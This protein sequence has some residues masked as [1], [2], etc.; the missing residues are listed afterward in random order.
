MLNAFS[1]DVEEHFQVHNFDARIG[2]EKWSNHESRLERSIDR[3]LRLLER[4]Q[5]QATFFVLCWNAER[6]RPIVQR[7]HA[8]GHEIG[9]HGCMHRLIYEQSPAEFR[10]DVLESKQF[11]E[12]VIGEPVI[13]YRAPSYSITA[14]SLW[15]LGELRAAGFL[16]DSSIYPMRRRRYGIPTAPRHPHRRPEGMVEFP[17]ATWRLGG[18]NIPAAS[19]AYLRLLPPWVSRRAIHQ[20]NAAGHPAVANIHPWELDPE[21]PRLEGG[22][23]GGLT[24]YANL[25]LTERRLDQLLGKFRFG[26]LR[27]CLESAGL[28]G[29]PARSRQASS[30]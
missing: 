15:A 18:I 6:L 19:G 2:P 23:F 17:L 5:V 28:L 12:E 20:L 7:I 11:L 8:A 26:T 30:G 1:I 9:S 14:R 29:E 4:H 3:I 27:Q 24:H 10:S 16:Y 25:H 13:G 21:Q 22:Q